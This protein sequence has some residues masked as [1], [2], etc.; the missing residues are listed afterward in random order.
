M[1][2]C[3]TVAHCTVAELLLSNTWFI[4]ATATNNSVSFRAKG[5][6]GVIHK[7][8]HVFLL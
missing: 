3:V 8:L 4:I 1:W 6:Q 2:L 7:Q 5:Y